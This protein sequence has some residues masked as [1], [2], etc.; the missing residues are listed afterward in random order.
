MS[1][2]LFFI[3]IIA[4]CISTIRAGSACIDDT[5]CQDDDVCTVDYCY[6][7]TCW[8]DW[9]FTC[10]GNVLEVKDS[11][12]DSEPHLKKSKG[13]KKSSKGNKLETDV[14]TVDLG[15][16]APT[17]VETQSWSIGSLQVST[18]ALI[19]IAVGSVVGVV[20]VIVAVVLV[21]KRARAQTVT[22]DKADYYNAL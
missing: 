12:T 14:Q 1:C 20:L 16:P 7:G 3:C 19:G 2:Q 6:H 10:D 11:Q 8:N 22:K 13:N 21:V 4:F 17:K 9:I 15:H 5:T 18:S